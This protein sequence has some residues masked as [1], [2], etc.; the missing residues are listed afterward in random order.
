MCLLEFDLLI[1]MGLDPLSA[2]HPR[3]KFSSNECFRN[4]APASASYYKEAKLP[5]GEILSFPILMRVGVSLSC[6]SVLWLV[7]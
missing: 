4:A 2:I 6:E 3:C 1:L 7:L 5:N